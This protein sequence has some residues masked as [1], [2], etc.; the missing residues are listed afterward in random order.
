[1]QRSNVE[2]TSLSDDCQGRTRMVVSRSLLQELF[3]LHFAGVFF[4]S[5]RNFWDSHVRTV[6]IVLDRVRRR[7]KTA[8]FRNGMCF[9]SVMTVG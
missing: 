2:A 5:G 4:I 9:I 1:M 8:P 7:R 6:R 3:R